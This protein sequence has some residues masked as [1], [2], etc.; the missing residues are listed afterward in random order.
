[1]R[2]FKFRLVADQHGKLKEIIGSGGYN[3]SRDDQAET[4]FKT[5]KKLA[6]MLRRNAE[7]MG[8]GIVQHFKFTLMPD[9]TLSEAEIDRV[10]KDLSFKVML[11]D[12]TM[13]VLQEIVVV[14]KK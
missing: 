4:T 2:T 12:G 5:T 6:T 13:K 7:Y 8:T 11:S 9:E 3:L 1:M 14:R 10:K